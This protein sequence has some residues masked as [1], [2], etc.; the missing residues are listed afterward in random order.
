VGSFLAGVAAI[1]IG[2]GLG[3]ATVVCVVDG[4]PIWR[5][6]NPA[7]AQQVWMK[8]RGGAGA[9]DGPRPGFTTHPHET[10]WPLVSTEDH[11]RMLAVVNEGR[12][13]SGMP[14]FVFDTHKDPR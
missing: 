7:H 3:G 11:L 9:W 10:A 5:D 8:H 12:V 13:R 14:P 2:G 4:V 1:V 6:V